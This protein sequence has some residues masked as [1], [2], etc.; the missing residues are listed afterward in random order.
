VS[1]VFETNPE[2]C[3]G[4]FDTGNVCLFALNS[5][6]S[7][8]KHDLEHCITCS[9]LLLGACP[10]K[11]LANMRATNPNMQRRSRTPVQSSF[12]LHQEA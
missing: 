9:A 6:A 12:P 10:L 7:I 1:S 8:H 11:S 5:P 2:H 3:H 4:A